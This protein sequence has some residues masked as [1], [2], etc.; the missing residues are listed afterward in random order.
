MKTETLLK[1]IDDNELRGNVFVQMKGSGAVSMTFLN[2]NKDYS[3]TVHNTGE[4]AGMLVVRKSEDIGVGIEGETRT[5]FI[6][7]EEI[8]AIFCE[9]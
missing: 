3:C 6:E 9:R 8:S 4:Y 7:I 2:F 5:I 1:M